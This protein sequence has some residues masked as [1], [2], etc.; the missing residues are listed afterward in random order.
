M[1]ESVSQHTS[2]TSSPLSELNAIT[3]GLVL[4]F[5]LGLWEAF[6]LL[7]DPP[8]MAWG[9]TALH[10]IALCSGVGFLSGLCGAVIFPPLSALLPS[11][12]LARLGHLEDA[13]QRINYASWGLAFMGAYFPFAVGL[14]FA[15]SI[16]HGFNQ[17]S[18]AGLFV[19]LMG[20]VCVGMAGVITPR[21]AQIT[22]SILLRM[23][24]QGRVAS[25]SVGF[26]PWILLTLG[27]LIALLKILSLPLGAYQWSATLEIVSA[28]PIAVLISSA[29]WCAVLRAPKLGLVL[30]LFT[31][32][33]APLSLKGW[34]PSH[35]SNLLIPER[36][37][38]SS[39]ALTILRKLSDRDGDGVSAAFGGG[40][41][42]DQNPQINPLAKDIPD[43]GIDEN[44]MGGDAKT[45]PPPPKPDPS[46]LSAGARFG[47]GLSPEI[48][49]HLGG[50]K[51]GFEADRKPNVLMILVDTMRASHLDLYGY[52][53]ETMPNLKRF[54]QNAVTF[55][56]AFAHAPRT[57]FSIPSLLTGRYPSRIKWEGS[58]KNYPRVADDNILVFERFKEAGW[59]TEAV[60]AHWYF[61]EEKGINL[62]QGLDQWDNQ[63]EMSVKD[64]NTQ[65]EAEGITKRL[66]ARLKALAQ[67]RRTKPFF[68]FAHY[69]APH[70]RYMR[71][72][73][74]CG[75]LKKSW[76]H[77]EPRCQSHPSGCQFGD[78]KARSVQKLINAYDSEL[79]YVDLYL[80]QVFEEIE[81]LGLAEDTVVIITSDHGE[82]FKDR[83]PASLFH[84]RSVYNEELHVPLII[85]A[86][87][88]V[89]SRRKEIVGLV[90]IVPTL[91]ALAQIKGEMLDGTNLSTILP[92]Q[93]DQSEGVLTTRTLFLEQLPYPG[94]KVHMI[95]ALDPSGKKLIRDLTNNTWSLYQLATDWLER[96][97]LFQKNQVLASQLQSDLAQYIDLTP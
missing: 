38:L 64:S 83:K 72:Q 91:T 17:A 31:L 73:T 2:S 28:I 21:L 19:A 80:Q 32:I 70:G 39:H 90:D 62:A 97:D 15:T 57:P 37:Q 76:C 14:Y 6:G 49:E 55:E 74:D 51:A 20:A 40:D 22:R 75:A 85:K 89:A 9:E 5:S 47:F 79:A 66:T 77:V 78:P 42:D 95:A 48:A 23:A 1:T 84:G 87:R 33:G 46:S 81:R 43:N 16:A 4:G 35:S 92:V 7:I 25:I 50:V 8:Q 58:S 63:G 12:W 61:G 82:S 71:H 13:D 56:R 86:P 24:P 52:E 67:E 59:R 30:L 60:S 27:A 69:F 65:S 44:C 10:Q 96:D 34:D 29:S 93:G 3:V 88:I 54:A 68:M 18:L 41:C 26:L 36:A 53:R 11:S 45:P 94:H